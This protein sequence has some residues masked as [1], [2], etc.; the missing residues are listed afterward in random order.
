MIETI[1]D[2][3]TCFKDKELELIKKYKIKHPPTIGSMYEGL[4]H[5]LLSRSLF[6]GLD[7]K[8]TN[9]FIK[10]SS[11]KLSYEIDCMLVEGEGD[12]IPHAEKYIYHDDKV[13]AVIQ[14]KKNLYTKDLL[15]S[16]E[17]LRSVIKVTESG[18]LKKYMGM[19]VRDSFKGICKKDLPPKGELD[20]LPFNEQMIYHTLVLESYY[21]ARIVWGYNGFKS[22]YQLRE[23]L[24]KFL[25]KN[26]T[27][28]LKKPILGYGPINFPSLIICGNYS[29]FKCNGMPFGHPLLD[30]GFW[31]FY[32]STSLNPI[33]NLLEI[34]WT[35]LSYK[36]EELPLYIFGEDLDIEESH[37]FLNCKCVR[38]NGTQGWEFAYTPINRKKLEE[39]L[40]AKEWQPAFLNEAQWVVFKI[41]GQEGQINVEDL[42]FK[43]FIE[44]KGYEVNHFIKTLSDT[45]L[46]YLNDNTLRFLTD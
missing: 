30:D 39:P 22:E 17:N 37:A 20:K 28:D 16:F 24:I 7:L 19:L 5:E 11:S 13:L 21:P 26:I 42:S 36:Y 29:L 44:N 6:K 43:K 33:Y 8:V 15:D 46:V 18:E 2:L 1:A 14:V 25:S 23:S 9:G 40:K 27:T 12:K 38:K 35:R 4:T 3:L 41:L 32:L 45:G 34:I 31:P 10:S